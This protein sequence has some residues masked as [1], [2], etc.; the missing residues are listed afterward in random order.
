MAAAREHY[1][2]SADMMMPSHVLRYV[3]RL[4]APDTM[5]PEVPK[6]CGSHKW[7]KD[8]SCAKCLTW[9]QQVEQ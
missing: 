6:D 9:R 8:G 2:E 7:T 3:R 4:K 5:S 1:R